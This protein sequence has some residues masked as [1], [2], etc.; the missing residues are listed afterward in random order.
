MSIKV[1]AAHEAMISLNIRSGVN[2][3]ELK[4][5]CQMGGLSATI[6][7]CVR[8]FRNFLS[9]PVND[10]ILINILHTCIIKIFSIILKIISQV[11][12]LID[13][14]FFDVYVLYWSRVQQTSRTRNS[15]FN[16]YKYV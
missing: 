2:L 12:Q 10:V 5:E 15:T 7:F 6:G 9:L 11:K 16:I 14:L 3:E 8:F 4:E 1:E 13:S